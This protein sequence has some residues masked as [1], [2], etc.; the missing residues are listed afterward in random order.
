MRITIAI[1]NKDKG[2]LIMSGF[3][4]N[5]LNAIIQG[6]DGEVKEFTQEKQSS[7]QATLPEAGDAVNTLK[8]A[9]TAIIGAIITILSIINKP[10]FT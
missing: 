6:S 3:L 7:S 8:L 5:A 9:N 10:E 1:L 2:C 4:E